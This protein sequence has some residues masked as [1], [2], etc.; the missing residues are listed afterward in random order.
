LWPFFLFISFLCSIFLKV[1]FT[2][3][4]R[5]QPLVRFFNHLF[6]YLCILDCHHQ[7][8]SILLVLI[9]WCEPRACIWSSCPMFFI[10]IFWSLSKQNIFGFL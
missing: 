7:C 5:M 3:L 4:R 8:S 6:I 9:M 2:M 1:F 10:I